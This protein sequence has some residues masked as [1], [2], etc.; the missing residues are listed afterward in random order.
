MYAICLGLFQI[1]K[2]IAYSLLYSTRPLSKKKKKNYQFDNSR[3][4]AKVKFPCFTSH[5]SIEQCFAYG[6]MAPDFLFIH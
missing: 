5:T 2:Y 1:L 3:N 6:I 4:H